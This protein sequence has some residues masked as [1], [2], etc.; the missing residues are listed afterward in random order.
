[1]ED[2]LDG[3]HLVIGQGVGDHGAHSSA[4]ALT[5]NHIAGAQIVLHVVVIVLAKDVLD[6]LAPVNVIGALGAVGHE[7]LDGAAAAQA[8]QSPGGVQNQGIVGDDLL[9]G[10]D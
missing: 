6:R 7:N 1:L 5:A 3:K 8:V 2:A 4:G 9:G 10:P